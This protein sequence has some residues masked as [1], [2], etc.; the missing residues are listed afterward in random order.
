MSPWQVK[1]S[2][3]ETN[4]SIGTQ[5]LVEADSGNSYVVMANDAQSH[6][7]SPRLKTRFSAT[8]VADT[9][10]ST[11]GYTVGNVDVFSISDNSDEDDDHMHFDPAAHSTLRAEF[12]TDFSIMDVFLVKN[13][14]NLLAQLN[15]NRRQENTWWLS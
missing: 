15:M 6:A 14:A 10:F 13:M 9:Y 1:F 4:T 2:S 5:L 11:W 8:T 12:I 3:V 7:H